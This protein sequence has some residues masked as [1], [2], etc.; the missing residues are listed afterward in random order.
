M[1]GTKG[2]LAGA[3]IQDSRYEVPQIHGVLAGGTYK[4]SIVSMKK[5]GRKVPEFTDKNGKSLDEFANYV[6]AQFSSVTTLRV[7]I[8]GDNPNRVDFHLKSDGQPGAG[9]SA[10]APP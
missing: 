5:T 3:G 6:P 7:K 8:S 10:E 1:E 2:P 9:G 4:V